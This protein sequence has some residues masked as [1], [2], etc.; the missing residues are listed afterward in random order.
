MHTRDENPIDVAAAKVYAAFDTLLRL[1]EEGRLDDLTDAQRLRYAEQLD[2]L[3]N[4]A[5]FVERLLTAELVRRHL[6]AA[7]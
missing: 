4:R 7:V 3:E 5:A 6:S 1:V 2:Q